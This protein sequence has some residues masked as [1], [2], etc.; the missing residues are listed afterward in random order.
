MYVNE[1]ET[2]TIVNETRT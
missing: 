1:K 2:T